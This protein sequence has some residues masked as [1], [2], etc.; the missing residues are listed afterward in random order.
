MLPAQ[1]SC[2]LNVSVQLH[3]KQQSIQDVLMNS[4]AEDC[5]LAC[6]KP[7][8]DDPVS[9]EIQ[10]LNQGLGTSSTMPLSQTAAQVFY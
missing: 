4:L 7:D 9:Y 1:K 5:S 2:S 6:D 10:F 3:D 8:T